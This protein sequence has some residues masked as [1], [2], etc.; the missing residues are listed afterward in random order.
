M[1]ANFSFFLLFF[2]FF[3]LP[4]LFLSLF[5]QLPRIH[6]VPL[7]KVS[8]KEVTR[9][10]EKCLVAVARGPVYSFTNVH[11]AWYTRLSASAWQMHRRCT[12]RDHYIRARVTRCEYTCIT[13]CMRWDVGQWRRAQG[14]RCYLIIAPSALLERSAPPYRTW[15]HRD[16]GRKDD[17]ESSLPRTNS[18]SRHCLRQCEMQAALARTSRLHQQRAS[19]FSSSQVFN[20]SET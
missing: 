18:R 1:T 12:L 20:L 6:F 7:Q 15:L 5:I 17:E 11:Y 4:S 10:G 16:K 13:S 19:D 9:H 2:F 3:S 8:I 14:R